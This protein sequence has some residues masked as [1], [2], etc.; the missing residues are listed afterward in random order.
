MPASSE[1]IGP[2]SEPSDSGTPPPGEAGT[3]RRVGVPELLAESDPVSAFGGANLSVDVLLVS[4]GVTDC[5][6]FSGLTPDFFHCSRVV[7]LGTPGGEY[8]TPETGVFAVFHPAV[9]DLGQQAFD[10]LLTVTA[11]YDDPAASTCHLDPYEGPAPQPAPEE[12]LSMCRSML[13]ITEIRELP[14]R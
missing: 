10:R 14:T 8:P 5:P 4:A 9:E 2:S 6:S 7:L 12:V 3:A 11:H 1:A 13:V